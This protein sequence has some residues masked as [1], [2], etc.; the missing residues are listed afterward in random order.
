[1]LLSVTLLPQVV[2]ILG[3]ALWLGDLDSYYYLSLMPAAVLSVLLGATALVPARVSHV[4]CIAIFVGALMIVPA[5]LRVAATMF[6]MPEYR[7]LVAGSREVL[8]RRLPM[9]SIQ[10][11]FDLHPTS[12]PEF[13][14]RVLGGRIDRL[15]EWRAVIL[16]D[17][18]VTYS[19]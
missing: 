9:R 6:K 2:A 18:R 19:R 4:A 11:A 1:M 8:K 14:F 17:G 12:D 5:R 16:P 15:S 3:Y 7:A 13:V 10:P